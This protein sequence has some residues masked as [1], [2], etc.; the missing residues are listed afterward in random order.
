MRALLTTFLGLTLALA[1]CEGLPFVD[2]G[3]ACTTSVERALDIRVE[4]AATG[5]PIAD[6]AVGRARDGAFVDSL[7]VTGWSGAGADQV[8][9]TLGGVY[10]RPGL[11]DV[12]IL[13]PGYAR[14][15]TTGV[16]VRKGRCHVVTVRFVARLHPVP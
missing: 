2:D 11:Y 5:R 10:E 8:A 6:R 4:D 16:R 14:W 12:E 9:T 1:G 7:R 13:R 15:D 3:Y